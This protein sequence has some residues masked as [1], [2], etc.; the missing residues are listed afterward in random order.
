MIS[1]IFCLSRLAA[2]LIATAAFGGS[3]AFAQTPTPSPTPRRHLQTPAPPGPGEIA[4]YIVNVYNVDLNFGPLGKGHREGI[5]EVSGKL[6]RQG[7]KYVGTVDAN[8]DSIQS[9]GGLGR[10]CS[11]SYD[12]KQKLKVTAHKADPFVYNVSRYT[13]NPSNEYFMLEFAPATKPGRQPA[14]FNEE[15]NQL[16]VDCHDLIIPPDFSGSAFLPFNDTR[17]TSL[18]EEPKRGYVIRLPV[19]GVLTYTD[20]QSPGD[21]GLFKVNKSVWTIRVERSP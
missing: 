9:L 5:D 1:K 16:S 7:S 18:D 2:A 14:T 21:A 19:S 13:G 6:T 20:T 10:G 12:D 11:G 17:W 15:T 4:I 8:V 3:V